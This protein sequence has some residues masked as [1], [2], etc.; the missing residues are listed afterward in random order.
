M[1]I[2][3]YIRVSTKRQAE[4]HFGIQ[5][6]RDMM[7]KCGVPEANIVTEVVSSKLEQPLRNKLLLE[8]RKG[9]VIYVYAL[10][11]LGRDFIEIQQIL[12]DLNERGIIFKTVSPSVI[13]DMSGFGDGD[14]GM[15]MRQM[16]ISFLA[17][18]AQLERSMINARV[19]DGKFSAIRRGGNI[20]F[21][22]DTVERLKS[23]LGITEEDVIYALIERVT[24]GTP[25]THTLQERMCQS[26][27]DN[28]TEH[29]SVWAK[30]V[31]KVFDN[32]QDKI[33]RNKAYRA[34]IRERKNAANNFE[35]MTDDLPMF[36]GIN[37][38]L[39][40]TSTPRKRK[41]QC[42]TP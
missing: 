4:E 27:W 2:Y 36:V 3:G 34:A 10:D 37:K 6:Q 11:R 18:G 28:Y 13:N 12:Q 22:P 9:D 19:R 33:N 23:E 15:L 5:T 40:G 38:C 30:K 16:M 8:R 17:F 25:V 29:R 32:L 35:L 20:V 42:Y 14:Q 39:E 24:C 1:A 31:Q 21:K 41:K 26:F 7:V